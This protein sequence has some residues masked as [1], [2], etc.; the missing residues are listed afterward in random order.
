[1]ADFFRGTTP[2]LIIDV[3]ADLSAFDV[4]WLTLEDEYG[5]TVTL[6]KSDLTIDATKV[7]AVLTQQQTLELMSG[8]VRAQIR[9]LN[10]TVAAATDIMSVDVGEILKDGVITNG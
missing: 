6:E 1:M 2:T 7:S 8:R 3:G 9:A 5:H 4:V 10:G